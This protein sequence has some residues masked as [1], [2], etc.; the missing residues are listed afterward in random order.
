MI[1]VV[2]GMIK[3]NGVF[4]REGAVLSLDDMDEARAVA[5]GLAV[6]CSDAAVGGE[7]EEGDLSSVVDPGGAD[8]EN[9]DP[10]NENAAPESENDAAEPESIG[11]AVVGAQKGGRKGKK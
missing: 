8:N 11:A 3:V 9:A 7:A 6:A 10:D 4:H 5:M 2:K 1:R